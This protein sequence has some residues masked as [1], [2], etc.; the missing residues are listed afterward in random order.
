[1]STPGRAP[2]V[3]P[4]FSPPYRVLLMSAAT[5]GW[6]QRP[7]NSMRELVVARMRHFFRQWE[8]RGATLLASMDDDYFLV[9]Q[10]TSLEYTIFLI[11]EVPSLDIVADLI[12][13]VREDVEGVRLDRYFRFEA[14]VGRQL[15]VADR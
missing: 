13:S 6:F 2:Y 8:E 1:M 11:Y 14:R 4:S 15:F 12:A 10:P 3:P 9:G 5:E 7:D